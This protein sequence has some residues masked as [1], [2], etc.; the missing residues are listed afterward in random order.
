MGIDI[1]YNSV[2]DSAGRIDRINKDMRNDFGEVNSSIKE[3]D[4]A[5]SGHAS[6]AAMDICMKLRDSLVEQQY[7]V[8]ND[9]VIFLNSCVIQ[10]YSVQEKIQL[11]NAYVFK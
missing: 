11:K 9:F 1:D 2:A 4:G 3:L 6:N 8:I 5:W 10:G 7:D